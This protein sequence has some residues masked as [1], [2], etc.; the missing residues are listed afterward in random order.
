M[1]IVALG[2]NATE[3]QRS[4]SEYHFRP[5]KQW[6]SIVFLTTDPAQRGISPIQWFI[7]LR[8]QLINSLMEFKT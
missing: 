7:P 8:P 4:S 2:Y 1:K 5:R 3:W 6:I